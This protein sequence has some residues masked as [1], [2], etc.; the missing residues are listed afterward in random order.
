MEVEV[1]QER[2]LKRKLMNLKYNFNVKIKRRLNNII[3]IWGLCLF[4]FFLIQFGHKYYHLSVYGEDTYATID[5]IYED[6]RYS[7][8]V[9]YKFEVENKQYSGNGW[10]DSKIKPNLGEKYKVK[11]SSKDPSINKIKYRE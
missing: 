1:K 7:K 10:Y 8:K 5:S 11:Y 4:V 9:L 6:W 2:K 3:A